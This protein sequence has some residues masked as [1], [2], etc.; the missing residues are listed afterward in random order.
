MA[1]SVSNNLISVIVPVYNSQDYLDACICSICNQ[2]YDNIEIIIIDDGSTDN[3]GTLC[4][5]YARSDSR[6]RVIHKQNEGLVVAR[7]TGLENACGEYITFVDSDDYIDLDSYE[8][9]M[10]KLDMRKPDIVLYELVEDYPDHSCVKHNHFPEGF[11]SK[12]HIRKT[13]IPSMLCYGDFFDFGILP[14]LV[15]KMIKREF[16]RN[17]NLTVDNRIMIGEDVAHTFQLIPQANDLMIIEY[18]PYHYCKRYDSMMWGKTDIYRIEALRETLEDCFY[19]LEINE[20]ME[21]QLKEYISFV[22]LLKAPFDLL[23]KYR[24]FS[25]LHLRVALYG[26][27]G[28]GQAVY[29][30]FSRSI[31][32]WVDNNV[33]RFQE[34]DIPVKAV[35]CLYYCKEDYDVVFVAILNLKTCE[36]VSRML[37]EKGIQKRIFYF[38]GRA[39]KCI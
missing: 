31:S 23:R 33:M 11:Y 26:A 4:D 29:N 24:P 7:K 20:I 32:L 21:T 8:V 1:E 19:R 16:L 37:R 30:S 38:D 27:G 25:N 28:M 34:T 13:I 15:C 14:N 12:E 2:T 22:T 5:A 35:D 17:V 9:L 6:I 18:A 39:V 10:R 3:S 36:L